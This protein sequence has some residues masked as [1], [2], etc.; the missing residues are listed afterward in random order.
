[1]TPGPVLSKTI[2]GITWA[3]DYPGC[4]YSIERAP[5]CALVTLVG[6]GN[7]RGR[8]VTSNETNSS[9]VSRSEQMC[10][11]GGSVDVVEEMPQIYLYRSE[12][13]NTDGTIVPR[14]RGLD[15]TACKRDEV[16]SCT[17]DMFCLVPYFSVFLSLFPRSTAMSRFLSANR[18]RAVKL[19][20]SS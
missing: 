1:M 7:N 8:R 10:H 13:G 17:G 18:S 12:M 5:T 19:K 15:A 4:T 6:R 14:K 2:S 20:A 16:V 9:H 3:H 11:R